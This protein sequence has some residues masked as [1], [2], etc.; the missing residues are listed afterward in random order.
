MRF[1]GNISLRASVLL[2]AFEAQGMCTIQ[3]S[4][5]I[6]SVKCFSFQY[7]AWH[8][9]PSVG[10]WTQQPGGVKRRYREFTTLPGQT[11]RPSC[12]TKRV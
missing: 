5:F 6:L 11:T 9:L 3:F 12:I 2:D 4:V 8:F 10:R 1:T 7:V